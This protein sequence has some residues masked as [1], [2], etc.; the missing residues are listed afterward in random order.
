MAVVVDAAGKGL[1]VRQGIVDG[2]EEAAAIDEAVA[3]VDR[4]GLVAAGDLPGIVDAKCLGAEGGQGIVEGGVSAAV[5]VVEEAVHAARVG[6][7]PDD[8]PCTID[9][10]REGAAGAGRGV[11]EGRVGAAVGVVE[12]AV[13]AAGVVVKPDDLARGVDALCNRAARTGKGKGIVKGGEG[14]TTIEETVGDAVV[15]GVPADD[16]VRVVDAECL[17]AAGMG[18]RIIESGER[19]DRHV[20]LLSVGFRSLRRYRYA[21]CS[22]PIRTDM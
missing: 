17:G 10:L 18:Q 8:Q 11:I 4:P 2:G 7:E 19:I 1:G 5:G 15:V 22:G 6:V 20:V 21:K 9:A 16:L 12:E 3:A 14:T 13:T